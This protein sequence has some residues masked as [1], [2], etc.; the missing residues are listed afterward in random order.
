MWPE[1]GYTPMRLDFLL[2]KEQVCVTLLSYH[3]TTGLNK[4]TAHVKV[5]LYMYDSYTMS[6]EHVFFSE[7]PIHKWPHSKCH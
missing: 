2:G 6:F 5:T 3:G 4:I 1:V 7:N